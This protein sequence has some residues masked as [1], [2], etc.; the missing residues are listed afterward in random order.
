MMTIYLVG[1]A[2]RDQLLEFPVREKDW[3]VVGATVDEMLELGF[4]QV[5]RDFPVFLHPE[6]KEEYALARTERKSAAGYT[7]F[8]CH[9]DPDVTLEQD[10]QRRDLTINAMARAEDDTLIDPYGGRRD[11]ADKILRHVSDAFVEDPLRV[12]RVARFAARYAHLGFTVAAETDALMG[13]IVD[14]GELATLSAERVWR[15]FEK[16]L[17][18]QSPGVFLQVMEK[19]GALPAL[20]PELCG[21]STTIR[22]ALSNAARGGAATSVRFALL[23]VETPKNLTRQFC[24]RLRVPNEYRKLALLASELGATISQ[25]ID[26]A[27]SLLSVIES[28]DAYRNPD[29]LQA[30]LN[31]I[32]WY[33][34]DSTTPAALRRALA[35][36]L[37]VDTAAIAA[38]G[39]QGKAIATE[40]RRQRNEAIK[41]V[42]G[43]H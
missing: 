42:C 23:F 29:R 13:R 34:P 22:S 9:A 31:C 39:L 1:G 25:P 15:E 27:E 10:L 17:G 19:C 41:T 18:E 40:I 4:Q 33:N 11:L 36:S 35:A 28:S 21:L 5:G 24:E 37:Q 2:V 8:V 7:G 26:S 20:M 16:A 3:V 30:L 12:L 38:S 14:S 43:R 6:S 32:G